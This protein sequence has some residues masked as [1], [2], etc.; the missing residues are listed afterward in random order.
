MKSYFTDTVD[1]LQCLIDE[2]ENGLS[3][4]DPVAPF[5]FM[6]L[7]GVKLGRADVAFLLIVTS[8]VLETYII[9]F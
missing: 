6:D 5:L 2:L 8:M 3:V 1:S 7:K 9:F 4:H